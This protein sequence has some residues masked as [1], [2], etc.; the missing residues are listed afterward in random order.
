[1]LNKQEYTIYFHGSLGETYGKEANQVFGI[2]VQEAFRWLSAKYGQEFKNTIADNDWHITQGKRTS[3]VLTEEDD[4]LD[5]SLVELPLP[6]VELHVFP[7]IA[8][9]GAV[10]KVIV[11]VV[12]I[13]VAV[14]MFWNPAGWFAAGAAGTMFGIEAGTALMIGLAGV[15][16]LAQG[17]I[18]A[19]SVTPT[20][21]DYA[22]AAGADPKASF[23]FNGVVNNTEQGVPV[24]LVYGLHLTGS[25][26]ISAGIDV[27]QMLDGAAFN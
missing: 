18:E 1:M 13:I 6:S 4:F 9:S 15:G 19:T 16:A 23:L 22:S 27:E 17:I 7:V 20:M 11:G 25:T 26:V 12:L 21:N 5:E 14:V 24:P 3:E 8:G 2:N 10:G